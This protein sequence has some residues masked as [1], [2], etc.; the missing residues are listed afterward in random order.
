MTHELPPM[1][2]SYDALEPHIDARTMEIHYTKHHQTYVDKLNL[3]LEGHPE[4][5]KKTAE[6]L[7]KDLT[8]V[9]EKIREAVR[10]HGGGHAN[11]SFFWPIMEKDVE[12]SGRIEDAIVSRFGSFDQFKTEFS[13]AAMGRFGSG[14]AWLVLTSTPDVHG[15]DESSLDNTSKLEIVSTPNQDNPI[16]R[17]KIPVLGIDVWEHAYYLKYQSKRADYIAAWF[18]VINWEKVN[19]HFTKPGKHK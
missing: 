16:T 2:Y 14:W 8:A 18:N 9:P 12:L 15:R 1:H 7:I 3:A 13:N 4:L 5:Q 19:E 17:G 6:E 10:N 11:H